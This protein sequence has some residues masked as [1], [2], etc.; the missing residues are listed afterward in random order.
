[1]G[2][3]VGYE[4]CNGGLQPGRA[5]TLLRVKSDPPIPLGVAR[6]RFEGSMPLKLCGPNLCNIIT[7]KRD[8]FSN[9]APR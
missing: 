2:L 3:K 7:Q 8:P 6:G 1:M 5:G 4:R 9:P